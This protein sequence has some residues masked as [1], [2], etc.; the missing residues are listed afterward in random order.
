MQNWMT[1]YRL[2]VKTGNINPKKTL[3][4]PKIFNFTLPPTR[5]FARDGRT[6]TDKFKTLPFGFDIDRGSDRHHHHQA[7]F[8][9]ELG[10]H[11]A[12]H[13]AIIRRVLLDHLYDAL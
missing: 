3:P 8:A 6:K 11:A 10:D 2:S 12:D 13:P 1:Q 4:C 5:F 7:I 9:E